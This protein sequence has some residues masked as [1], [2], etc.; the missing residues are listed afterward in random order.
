MKKLWLISA[1]SLGLVVLAW[2]T[3]SKPV[4]ITSSDDMANL[5]NESKEMTCTLSFADEEWSATYTMY[6][7][8]WMISQL[9]KEV[10]A[11]WEE[12]NDY[13]LARDGMMYGWWDS[14]WDGWM[15]LEY[16]MDIADE[17]WELYD[18]LGDTETLTCVKW[19][20]DESVFEKPANIEFSSLNDLFWGIE[21]EYYDEEDNGEYVEENSEV[22]MDNEV[23]EE[24]NE[25]VDE[26]IE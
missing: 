10:T 8:D 14:Y 16:E 24:N 21:E 13:A 22:E 17:F 11:D 2:C 4:T 26:V 18:S 20:K 25:V 5:Y 9:S 12:Y 1:L 3:T 19:V 6:F 7:K 23:A 15:Y